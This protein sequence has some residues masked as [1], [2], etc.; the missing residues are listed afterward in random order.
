[1][2]LKNGRLG[3]SGRKA[4]SILAALLLMFFVGGSVFNATAQREATRMSGN[5]TFAGQTFAAILDEP[6]SLSAFPRIEQCV[7]FRQCRSFSRALLRLR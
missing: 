6:A 7:Y 2:N 5:P 3:P 4:Q 1:M